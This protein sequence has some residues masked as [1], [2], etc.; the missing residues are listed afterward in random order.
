VLIG[1]VTALSRGP[2]LMIVFFLAQAD[3]R[4]PSGPAALGALFAKVKPSCAQA[5]QL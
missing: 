3:K 4:V 1:A 2:K 5:R